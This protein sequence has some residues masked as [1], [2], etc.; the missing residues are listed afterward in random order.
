MIKV[1]LL[2]NK[3]V[4]ATPKNEAAPTAV[5][6]AGFRTT[7]RSSGS[8][9]DQVEGVLKILIMLFG[10][11]SLYGYQIYMD[12]VSK[13]RLNAARS[14]MERLRDLK[15]EKQAR[16]NALPEIE[17]K[18]AFLQARVNE[19]DNATR[20]RLAELESLDAI[21]SAITRA[22]WVSSVNY[23]N[24]VMSIQGSSYSGPG[25]DEFNSNLERQPVFKSVRFNKVSDTEGLNSSVINFTLTA[26][27]NE[28]YVSGR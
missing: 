13:E 24:G 28:D 17:K 4:V 16:A 7:S 9:S 21:Q 14:E 2:K 26:E 27:V 22:A 8:M 19:F 18:K 10:I 23:E 20:F 6:D 1:N 12:R 5:L 11:A 3:G 25:F 15:I